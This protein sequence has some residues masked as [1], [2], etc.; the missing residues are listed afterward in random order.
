MKLALPA[1]A[2][3]S[4]LALLAAPVAHAALTD[5]TDFAEASYLRVADGDIP[6]TTATEPAG[7]WNLVEYARV[8][9]GASVAARFALPAGFSPDGADCTCGN[10]TVTVLPSGLFQ[11]ASSAAPSATTLVAFRAHHAAG[12]VAFSFDP[13]QSDA[14]TASFYLRQGQSV[15]SGNTPS[16]KD[17][18]STA[19]NPG[20]FITSFSG[21]GSGWFQLGATPSVPAPVTQT[22]WVL[23]GVALV[24]GAFVW[25]FLVS[26]G[27][28]QKK[29]RKQVAQVAAH[30]E[31]AAADPAPV[32]EGKKR[33]LL[34]ALKE[35]E[36]ARQANEMPTDVYDV[37]KADLKKQAVTVMRALETGDAKP[38]A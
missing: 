6:R 37:V 5:T 19:E 9:S 8:T 29:G 22:N 18:P 36:L 38:K 21:S 31:A 17:L 34:A 33:A 1:L 24:A 20:Y 26:R 30:V 10:V 28:V 2:A 7:Q 23:V 25:A 16:T 12:D 32:L 11:V 35:V 15:Q 14:W 3:L 4:L 27:L 13:Q